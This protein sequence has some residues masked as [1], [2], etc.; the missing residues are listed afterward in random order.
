LKLNLIGKSFM[1]V[2]KFNMNC[3]M[4][5]VWCKRRTLEDAG[6]SDHMNGVGRSIHTEGAGWDNLAGLEQ[7]DDLDAR[8]DDL[9]SVGHENDCRVR[10]K[11]AALQMMRWWRVT[12]LLQTPHSHAGLGRATWLPH[13]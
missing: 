6:W 1:G 11:T 3:W 5:I 12:R 7:D 10:G 2:I 9:E 13:L 8:Q 4:M